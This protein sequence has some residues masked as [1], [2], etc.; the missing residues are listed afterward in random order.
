PHQLGF[1][2]P[3]GLAA[4]S[5]QGGRQHQLQHTCLDREGVLGGYRSTVIEVADVLVLGEHGCRQ[6]QQQGDGWC[7]HRQLYPREPLASMAVPTRVRRDQWCIALPR[8]IAS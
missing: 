4:T 7:A 8:A 1:E 3:V 2:H 6:G 5:Y